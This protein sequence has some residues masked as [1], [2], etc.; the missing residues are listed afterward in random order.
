M[1][2]L[3]PLLY[4][5]GLLC[6]A[7][8][9]LM[10][11]AQTG[12]TRDDQT[13]SPYFLITTPDVGLDAFA[14]K[15]TRAEVN[16]AGVI[17]EVKVTQVYQN[18]GQKP[19]E[20]IYVF[21]ASTRAAVYG[22]KMTIGERTLVAE[23]KK[24]EQARADYEQAKTEG[25]SAT[26][27][28]QQRPNVFQMNVAN[29]LPG[30]EIKV[31]MQ[32]TERLTSTR[33]V[34]EFVYPTVVGPRYSNR[35]AATAPAGE[36]WVQNP[37]LPPG[38][39]APTGFGLTLNLAAGLPV[40]E[41]ASSS[42]KV[43]VSYA[44]PTQAT[45][46][47]DPAETGGGNRDFILKYRLAGSQVESGLLLYAGETENFFLLTMQPPAQVA[48]AQI[49]PR[50]YVFVM[51]VSGSMDGFPLEISK[52]LFKDLLGQL[53]PSDRFNVLMFAG[54]S[55][56]LADESLLATPDHQRQ[57]LEFMAGAQGGGGTELRMAL[58]RALALPRTEGVSRT[59]VVAT[60]GYV[61]VEQDTF[62]LIRSHLDQMNLFA[63]G[64]G[65]SVNRFLIEG[66]ARAGMGEPFVITAPEQAPA[67][68]AAF[69]QLIATP[70]LTGIQ[71]QYDSFAAEAMEPAHIPDVFAERPV[72]VVGQWRGPANGEIVVTGQRGGQPYRQTF[73][74]GEVKPSPANRALRT[75]WARQRIARLDDDQRLAH[76]DAQVQEVTE[77]GLR[78]NLLTAY[79]SFVAVDS[80]VRL[81]EGAATT[82][83]QP[84]PL[85]QGVPPLAVGASSG[86]FAGGFTRSYAQQ[87]NS[88]NRKAA[89][90]AA[91][92]ALKRQMIA[93]QAAQEAAAPAQPTV[94]MQ[95][96]TVTVERGDL[97]EGDI[98]VAFNQDPR[99]N[100]CLSTLITA[101]KWPE[102]LNLTLV[103]IVNAKGQVINVNKR[104][105]PA[106]FLELMMPCLIPAIR[107]WQLPTGS[108]STIVWLTLEFTVNAT[109]K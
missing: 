36:R 54:G 104:P 26:L 28:E 24:R 79:T 1:P 51:D 52:Q 15:E 78:Y 48:A 80:Q 2:A 44:N 25:R 27:L 63:F 47:L 108:S 90:I 92:A 23:I 34:Y 59:V 85:P 29:I 40:Q 7:T 75:L 96:T 12:E 76:N 5:F 38:T 86:S 77:L 6:L 4:A 62:E 68:A 93:D 43:N 18:H 53:R 65:T 35:P 72:V 60:D 74:V 98:R 102:A 10:A 37:Y 46:T 88:A 105:T 57:A 103:L 3:K 66:M 58:Q 49:P 17:A 56:V 14:L 61:D 70:V 106:H 89:E 11:C 69:R 67:Q 101:A 81:K 30:D 45:V 31:E 97:T 55:A 8:A 19:L 41:I 73:A 100:R 32:Y 99:I 50:E 84:L 82:V 42:H 64:I 94:T 20:A 91:Q 95:L 22:L 107:Q 109:N 16:I 9:S 83:M 87:E 33:Q 21:P 13:L 71:V 39:P